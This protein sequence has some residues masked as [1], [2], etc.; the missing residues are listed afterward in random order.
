MLRPTS[1]LFVFNFLPVGGLPRIAHSRIELRGEEQRIQ[2]TRKRE[3]KE[4]WR[5]LRRKSSSTL[6]SQGARIRPSAN[7]EGERERE[8]ERERESEPLA[9]RGCGGRGGEQ[10]PHVRY[11]LLSRC[12][13]LTFNR[14]ASFYNLHKQTLPIA[15]IYYY[16][17]FFLLFYF[18]PNIIFQFHSSSDLFLTLTY[19]VHKFYYRLIS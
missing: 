2:T 10:S 8:R 12:A 13:S 14:S 17:F 5:S 1:R 4:T 11:S 9:K 7:G 15:I 3:G 6:T 18:L 16:S 19:N